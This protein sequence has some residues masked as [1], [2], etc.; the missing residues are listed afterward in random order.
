[1][2]LVVFCMLSIDVYR[3]LL[4]GQRS[5]TRHD[6]CV[7]VLPQ[8]GSACKA[9]GPFGD[10][11]T[12]LHS[13]TDGLAAPPSIA[14]LLLISATVSNMECSIVTRLCIHEARAGMIQTSGAKGLPWG[15]VIDS[16]AL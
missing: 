6:F 12:S 16:L 14:S 9:L 8:P 3:V 1:V 5:E 7:D 2:I 4:R 15:H 13:V 10:S 11:L